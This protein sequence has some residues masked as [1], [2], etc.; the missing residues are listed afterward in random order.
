MKV[1]KIRGG[2]AINQKQFNSWLKALRSGEYGQGK[3]ALNPNP[4]IYCCL[5]VAC[6]VV[7]P[8]NEQD[9]GVIAYNPPLLIGGAPTDQASAP[10]WLKMISSDFYRRTGKSLIEMNDSDDFT[11]EEIAE[12]LELVY[13]RGVLS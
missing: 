13:V 8:K 3:Y 5:G 10:K 6:D 7:I 2:V 11:F 4:G 1:K 12:L 9:R